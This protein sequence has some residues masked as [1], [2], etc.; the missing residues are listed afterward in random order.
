MICHPKTSSHT[1]KFKLGLPAGSWWKM[2]VE[3][4]ILDIVRPVLELLQV[5][6][7]LGRDGNNSLLYPGHL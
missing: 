5:S 7:A 3:G 2:V 6:W 1:V 4:S